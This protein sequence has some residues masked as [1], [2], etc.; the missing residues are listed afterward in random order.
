M[1]LPKQTQIKETISLFSGKYNYKI[2]LICPVAS[3]FR[4]K[5]YGLVED[6][7]EE[8]G[9][10]GF[11]GRSNKFKTADDIK[12]CGNL[13]NLLK[14][15]DES[16][17]DIRVESP[18]INF[19]TNDTLQVEKL[20]GLDEERVKFISVP[21]KSLQKLEP[22][23]VVV[24]TLDYDYKV[25]LGSIKRRNHSNFVSW[26]EKNPKIRLTKRCCRDLS[27]DV[28]WGGA[29]FYVK[30]ERTLTMVK[31]FLGSDISRVDRVIKA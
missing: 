11:Y 27:H 5:N 9:P 7:L 26:A 21:G 3:W 6:N 16:T 31:M 22:G 12:Y 19:Y 2:V 25:Y 23:K 13:V 18:R 30:D 4:G 15:F 20:A 8:I 10:K 24:K 14:T 29:Y 28:S 17:Y 1:K